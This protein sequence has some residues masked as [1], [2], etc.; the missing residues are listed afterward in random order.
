CGRGGSEPAEPAEPYRGVSLRV[1]VLGDPTLAEALDDRRGEWER[2]RGGSVSIAAEDQPPEQADLL[3]FRGDRLGALIDADALRALPES[4][5]A[6]PEPIDA[7]GDD[8]DEQAAPPPDPLA[9]D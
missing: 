7:G 2:S 9:F 1:A 6:P 5:V 4:L 3:V 8:E